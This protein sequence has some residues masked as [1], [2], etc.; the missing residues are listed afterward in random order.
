MI[1]KSKEQMEMEEAEY[2]ELGVTYHKF[3]D[4]V[5][6]KGTGVFADMPKGKVYK[7]VHKLTAAVLVNK[8]YAEVVV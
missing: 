8:K 1:Y 7:R 3:R 4:F 6:V 5:T 2:V